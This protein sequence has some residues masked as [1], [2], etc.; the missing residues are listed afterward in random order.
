MRLIG[1]VLVARYLGL[2]LFGHLQFSLAI[3]ALLVPFVTLGLQSIVIKYLAI[4]PAQKGAIG[5]QCILHATF[6]LFDN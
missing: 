5:G 6:E 4:E 3:M 2:E 1:G